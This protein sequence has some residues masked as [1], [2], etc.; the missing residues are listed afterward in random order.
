MNF[1]AKVIMVV[2]LVMF[3]SAC[4]KK[5][6]T[7]AQVVGKEATQDQA[8]GQSA[9]AEIAKK[10]VSSPKETPE[11]RYYFEVSEIFANLPAD[12]GRGGERFLVVE[13]FLGTDDRGVEQK[14]EQ[15]KHIMRFK[16]MTVLSSRQYSEVNLQAGKAAITSE[17]ML[18]A[19]AVL[20]PELT[21]AYLK[22]NYKTGETSD[23]ID[24]LIRLG[25]L[26]NDPSNGAKVS[27][28]FVTAAKKITLDSLPIKKI[29]FKK[30]QTQ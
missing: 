11:P 9:Q 1:S 7:P 4:S 17:L 6:E 15:L 25:V 13:I 18:A 3:L 8:Q 20:E 29:V 24:R 28:E 5:A 10:E 12:R 26:P 2:T 30:F 14:I 19:N 22:Y 23:N 27:E 16:M 21:A